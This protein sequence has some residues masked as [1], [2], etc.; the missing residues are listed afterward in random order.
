MKKTIVELHSEVIVKGFYYHLEV[1][2]SSA[3]Y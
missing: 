3:K 2:V 1:L